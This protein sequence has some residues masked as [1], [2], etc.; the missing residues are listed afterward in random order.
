M[1]ICIIWSIATTHIHIY[2]IAQG[3]ALPDALQNMFWSMRIYIYIYSLANQ[4]FLALPIR[5]TIVL[6]TPSAYY[7]YIYIYSFDLVLPNKNCFISF[8]VVRSSRK[9]WTNLTIAPHV[10]YIKTVFFEQRKRET[11]CSATYIYIYIYTSNQVLVRPRVEFCL[12]Q[13]SITDHVY[14]YIYI[15]RLYGLRSANVHRVSFDLVRICLV[16]DMGWL[17]FCVI[18]MS[19]R[20]TVKL[21][22][23]IPHVYMNKLL[24]RPLTTQLITIWYDD[25]P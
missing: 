6:C 20:G 17:Q 5:R 1:Q 25:L 11:I 24:G 16:W 10:L 4:L 18:P 23:H 22:T 2:A 14:I 8:E 7:I 9:H 3:K 21:H 19:K 12:K 13:P 15:G